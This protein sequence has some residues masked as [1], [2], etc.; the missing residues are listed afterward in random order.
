MDEALPTENRMTVI[1]LSVEG[2]MLLQIMVM[3]I[4]LGKSLKPVVIRNGIFKLLTSSM[5]VKM[6]VNVAQRRSVKN[7]LV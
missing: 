6:T 7:V 4:V 2:K 3:L 5:K 1:T